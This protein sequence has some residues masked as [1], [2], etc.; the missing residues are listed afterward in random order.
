MAAG[1]E[2]RDRLDRAMAARGLA[3]SR[4]RARALVRAG[5]VE[6]D[7]RPARKPSAPV[8]GGAEIVVAGL[9]H[10]WASRGGVKLAA[11]LDAFGIDPAGAD[12]LDIGASTGGFTDVL[13]ARGARRSVAVDVGREQLAA[14]LRADPRVV[15]LERTDA[16]S[17][18]AER[19]G[20]AAFDLAVCDVS[21]VS[22]R[23]ALPAALALVRPGGRLVALVKPQFEAGP[24]AVG[25]G[26]VVRDEAARRRACRE[27]EA[28]L[29]G[30]ADWRSDGLVPSPIDGRGGNREYLLA[31]T[32]AGRG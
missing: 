8:D 23:K 19:A 30:L 5:L 9:D 12:C 2:G 1:R 14:R 29:D 4:E 3:P 26:G 32:K 31:G 20:G 16:R 7:G 6:C 22:L 17:L 24:G 10:P 25:K 28:W 13:L 11:A 21:F 27:V 18:T 15:S